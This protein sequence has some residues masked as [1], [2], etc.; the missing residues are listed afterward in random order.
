MVIY[1]Y[2]LGGLS[3]QLFENTTNFYIFASKQPLSCDVFKNNSGFMKVFQRFFLDFHCFYC[4]YGQSSPW[5]W[6]FH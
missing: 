5:T 1:Y 4:V 6:P 2:L 3:L